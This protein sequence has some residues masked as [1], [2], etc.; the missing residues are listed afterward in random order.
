LERL[1]LELNALEEE[2][3]ELEKD[4]IP[5]VFEDEFSSKNQISEVNLLRQEMYKILGSEAFRS[6]EGRSAIE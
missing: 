6:I 4:E 1:A 2:L 5:N 3:I